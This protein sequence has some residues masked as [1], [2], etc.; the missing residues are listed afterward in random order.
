M[1]FFPLQGMVDCSDLEELALIQYEGAPN[2]DPPDEKPKPEI[3]FRK[4]DIVVNPWG[5]EAS[6]KQVPIVDVDCAGILESTL[7]K[8][9][10]ACYIFSRFI[11]LHHF[12]NHPVL[13]RATNIM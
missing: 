10:C 12:H 4:K 9:N 7:K 2:G 11:A 8:S 6:E 13:P 3:E 1:G 5:E